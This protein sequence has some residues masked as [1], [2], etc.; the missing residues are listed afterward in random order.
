MPIRAARL[1]VLLASST[2]AAS[3]GAALAN[4]PGASFPGQAR[5]GPH[6][7]PVSVRFFC[8]DNKG[9]DITGVLSVELWV[10][11]YTPL[12]PVFDFYAFEGPDADAGTRT[13]LTA[14][15]PTETATGRFTAAGWIA[16]S[17]H[18][19]TFAFGVAAARR[20]EPARLTQLA[21]VLRRLTGGAASLQWTQENAKRGGTPILASLTLTAEQSTQLN[22]AIGACLK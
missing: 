4:P 20:G 5:I 7:R 8:S 14:T 11:R 21:A 15:S 1:L 6:D 9:E 10:P 17:P 18:A 22:A 16:A 19:D 2:L 13:A 3:H 12:L